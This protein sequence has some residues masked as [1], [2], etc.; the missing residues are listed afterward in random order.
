MSANQINFDLL[1]FCKLMRLLK[2]IVFFF[3]VLFFSPVWIVSYAQPQNFYF[4]NY[5]VKDG[6]SYGV[7][8]DIC[9]D[10][11]GFLWIGTFNGLNRFD[12]TA[13]KT[14]FSNPYDS[15]GIIGNDVLRICEDHDGNIWCATSKGV[16][17]YR[18]S[19]NL[20]SNYHLTNPYGFALLTNFVNEILCDRHGTIWCGTGAGIFE[21]EILMQ[22]VFDDHDHIFDAICAGASGYILKT[23]SPSEMLAA[24]KDVHQGGSPMSSGVARRVLSRFQHISPKK[25]ETTDYLLTPR[26]KEVLSLIVQGKSYKMIAGDLSIGFETVRT[27]IKNI[28]SK[29]HVQSLAEMV[30]KAIRHKVV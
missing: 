6:I 4:R 5:G 7:V 3:T 26:E 2:H 27:H 20:F 22:T 30:A 21:Y 18:K 25:D 28:Y 9:R 11:E 24:I 15:T 19:A 8:N 10:S 16:S 1:S 29:L 14:F 12:G 17:R 13:F 23:T